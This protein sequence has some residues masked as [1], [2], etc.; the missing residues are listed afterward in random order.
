M[1]N[2]I[3]SNKKFIDTVTERLN[4]RVKEKLEFEDTPA[5]FIVGKIGYFDGKEVII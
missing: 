2:I 4:E 5:F 1:S 3:T